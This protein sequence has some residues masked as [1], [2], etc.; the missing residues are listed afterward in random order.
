MFCEL[1]WS[2]RFG[3]GGKQG[4]FRWVSGGLLGFLDGGFW[5]QNLVEFLFNSEGC[6]LVASCISCMQLLET[7]F[8]VECIF[9][10]LTFPALGKF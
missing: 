8:L 7:W 2:V 1:V 10:N 3:G 4:Y 6:I 9:V 5:L